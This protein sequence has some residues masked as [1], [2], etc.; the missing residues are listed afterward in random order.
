MARQTAG[1][2]AK[3]KGQGRSYWLYEHVYAD[4]S[5]LLERL[6]AML[7]EDRR[8]QVTSMILI[9]KED[10][11]AGLGR[12]T[13][14]PSSAEVLHADR[15]TGMASVSIG[16]SGGDAGGQGQVRIVKMQDPFVYLAVT[17]GDAAF[18]DLALGPFIKSL[19]PDVS[20]AALSSAEMRKALGALEQ[21]SGGE[22]RIVGM[23]ACPEQDIEGGGSDAD[24]EEERQ[25]APAACTNVPYREAFDEAARSSRRVGAVRALLVLGGSPRMECHI[26]R[27]CLFRFRRSIRPFCAG[28]L[29]YMA[30]LASDKTR[31]YSGRSR[32][33]N[34]GRFRA[35]AITLDDGAFGDAFENVRFMRIIR[36]MPRTMGSTYRQTPH[37]HMSLV[38][39]MDG[40]SF[41]VW[42]TSTNRI[43]IVPQLRATHAAVA[44]LVNHIFERFGEGRVEDYD[45][46]WQ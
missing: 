7:R 10:M 34:G 28:A 40:S 30:G 17:D 33:E 39:Y 2:V 24:G 35:L 23:D 44:R 1:L 9:C 27:R 21:A 12:W 29:P 25:W 26:S 19:Y 6:D 37:V 20:E 36:A 5:E 3:H 41:D 18:V 43:T 45:E 38:D 16:S 4:S 8:L 46:E 15:V 11:I 13:G 32:R 31:F 14:P 42:A 22:V